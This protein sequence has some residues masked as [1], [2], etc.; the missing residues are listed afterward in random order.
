MFKLYNPAIIHNRY[1]VRV[2][3]VTTKSD[4]DKSE[5]LG[6]TKKAILTLL[7]EGSKTA[8][9]IAD[10]LKIQKTAIRSHLESLR[11]EQAIKSYFKVEGPGRPRKVYEITESGRELF[12]RRY[13]LFSSLMLQS[14]ET[15]EGHEYAKRIARSVADSIAQG[16]QDKIKN[17]STDIDDSIKILNL[18]SNEMG[19]MSSFQKED[20]NSYSIISRNCIVHKIALS[21]QDSICHGFHDRIIL[22]ALEGKTNPEVNLR[23]CIALGDNYSRHVIS[24]DKG[25]NR[26]SP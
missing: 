5:I 4:R 2:T 15:A 24:V 3:T 9:E 20:D 21:N 17:S 7:I 23:E 13:D 10:K 11:A 26:T 1:P 12:P 14:I 8:G 16:I 25:S 6:D 22:K 18:A 19:F